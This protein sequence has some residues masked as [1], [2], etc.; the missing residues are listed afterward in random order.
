PWER[1]IGPKYYLINP[2][3][4]DQV[5]HALASEHYRIEIQLATSDVFGRL[6]LRKGTYLVRE[7]RDHRVRAVGIGRQETPAMRGAD[8]EA[9]KAVKRTFEDQMR[10]GYRGFE[11]VA[12]SVRQETISG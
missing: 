3:L 10:Q 11:R 1:V 5:P 2:C 4:S 9:W 7:G 6:L 12:Y 8:L